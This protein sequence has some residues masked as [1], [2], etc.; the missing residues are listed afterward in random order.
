MTDNTPAGMPDYSAAG[1]LADRYARAARTVPRVYVD[2]ITNRIALASADGDWPA[3]DTLTDDD[4]WRW[5]NTAN[6]IA[7][8]LRAA[9]DGLRVSAREHDDATDYGPLM[10]D[11][12]ATADRLEAYAREVI[13]HVLAGAIAPGAYIVDDIVCRVESNVTPDAGREGQLIVLDGNG[14][15]YPIRYG[16]ATTVHVLAWTDADWNAYRE[17]VCAPA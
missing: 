11:A 10:A 8:D 13:G 12:R 14:W 1:I 7:R 3:R 4:R 6:G 15:R 5:R 17:D 2:T 16:D 9:A